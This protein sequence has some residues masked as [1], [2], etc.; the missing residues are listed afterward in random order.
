MEVGAKA[1]FHTAR[2]V[3]ALS[4]YFSHAELEMGVLDQGLIMRAS[5]Q[6]ASGSL[7]AASILVRVSALVTRASDVL[8]EFGCDIPTGAR[9]GLAAVVFAATLSQI[10]RNTSF[11]LA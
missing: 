4:A 9:V 8:S 7:H 1:I 3:V 10:G 11:I 5:L 6:F 2:G